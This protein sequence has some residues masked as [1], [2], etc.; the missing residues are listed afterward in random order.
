[1]TM[2]FSEIVA[3]AKAANGIVTDAERD[4]ERAARIEADRRFAAFDARLYERETMLAERIAY[5]RYATYMESI[6]ETAI[7]FRSDDE[8]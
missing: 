4:A 2:T 3:A 1:M 7:T 8:R 5:V 6:G